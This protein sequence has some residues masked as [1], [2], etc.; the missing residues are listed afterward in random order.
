MEI[1]I[2]GTYY[3]LLSIFMKH[4]WIMTLDVKAFSSIKKYMDTKINT[5]GHRQ[6]LFNNFDNQSSNY[7][8]SI[9]PQFYPIKIY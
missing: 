9:L 7:P 1:Y 2:I 5:T 8:W 6:L 3:Y 4:F